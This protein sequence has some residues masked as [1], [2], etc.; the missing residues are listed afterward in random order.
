[1]ADF[2]K[3]IAKFGPKVVEEAGT[4][5]DD[6]AK[7]G[8][9]VSRLIDGG[10]PREEAIRQVIMS[11]PKAPPISS[12]VNA[13][14][15]LGPRGPK[16]FEMVP[17][18]TGTMLQNPGLPEVRDSRYIQN[19]AP[20]NMDYGSQIRDV[21]PDVIVP[22][23][24]QPKIGMGK[25][26]PNSILETA[27]E[28]IPHSSESVNDMSDL[29]NK[30]EDFT[31][32]VPKEMSRLDKIGQYLKNNKV[33]SA[34]LGAAGAGALLK[35]FDGDESEPNMSVGAPT[36]LTKETPKEVEKS[37]EELI[38]GTASGSKNEVK[39]SSKGVGSGISSPDASKMQINSGDYETLGT[40]ENLKQALQQAKNNQM[41]AS[42]G[43]IG[44][45]LAG[46]I[47]KVGPG[48]T[49]YWDEAKKNAD[50]PLKEHEM[51]VANEKN[52]P[53]S[54]LSKF[55]RDTLTGMGVK[56]TGNP[57]AAALEKQI[58]GIERMMALRENIAARKDAANARREEMS[59]IKDA[60]NEKAKD[61]SLYRAKERAKTR[62]QKSGSDFMEATQAAEYA[63]AMTANGDN[64]AEQISLLYNFVKGLDPRSTVREGE[65]AL[66][67]LGGGRI[68]GTISAVLGEIT[69]NPK[70][71]TPQLIKELKEE[72]KIRANNTRKRYEKVQESEYKLL[73]SAGVQE[74]EFDQVDPYY[75]M[76]KPSKESS[77]Q[78]PM[79]VRKDG[80][81]ATVKN[82]QELKEAQSEGWN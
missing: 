70:L 75:G 79:Q 59:A 35:A 52:D 82:E 17:D 42:L 3:L 31:S 18:K 11:R 21:T 36:D 38:R 8:A 33:K 30:G 63:D 6:M 61:E 76:T 55:Y 24:N 73:K 41:V 68:Q 81:V 12:Y 74:D 67:R 47:S 53:N 2:S 69:G 5:S 60:R 32:N 23:Y 13:E 62:L 28:S 40:Q 34:F 10:V 7:I 14:S 66:A 49:S 64:G 43:K 44:Q 46:H 16:S 45:Q 1:M 65:V 50:M 26:K 56:V 78:F 4:H 54:G 19:L 27:P 22:E 39:T 71:I 57:S 77:K 72:I 15:T 9:E 80:H 25:Q 29:Y 20:E 37:K 48:D 51:L 58:P